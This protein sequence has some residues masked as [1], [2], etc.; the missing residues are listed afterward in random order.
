MREMKDSGAEWIGKIPKEWVTAPLKSSFSFGKGLSITKA[1]LTETGI[2][3]ISYGQIHSKTCDGVHVEDNLLRYV[4]EE[5]V[6]E[7]AKVIRGGFIFADTSE[8]L[9]GC[10]NAVYVDRDDLYGGYHTI[11]LTPENKNE[12]NRYYGYLFRTDAWRLQ[13]RKQLTDVKLFSISQKSLKNTSI[14][15]PSIDE[16]IAI[17]N[18]LDERIEKVNEAI[19]RHQAI[20]EKL[21]EYKKSVIYNA[22][23]GKIDCR[24]HT[25][26]RG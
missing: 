13:I 22:V 17:A 20:I 26:D 6:N 9:D 5:I 12:D 18:F 7:N 1:D 10:G 3:V 4:P 11:V 23:T 16:R 15:V 2:P 25:I 8:D 21:E 19:T 24:N 14:L